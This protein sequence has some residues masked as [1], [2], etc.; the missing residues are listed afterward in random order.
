MIRGLKLRP[1]GDLPA[2]S[3]TTRKS[4]RPRRPRA[5]LGAASAPTRAGRIAVGRLIRVSSGGDVSACQWASVE[6]RIKALFAGGL[7][8]LA[9]FGAAMAGPLEDARAAYD[10]GAYG[11]AMQIFR[12]LA[13]HGNVIAQVYLGQM[14]V[15]GLGVLRDGPTIP[16]N[17]IN[18]WWYIKS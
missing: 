1:V 3:L 11:T 2:P 13:E 17:K 7:L 15:N 12:P 14:Y 18:G 16:R 8:A 10:R 4:S 6:Q 9:R 5:G